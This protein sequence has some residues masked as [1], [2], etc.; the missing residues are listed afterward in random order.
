MKKWK[1]DGMKIYRIILIIGL[2]TFITTLIY[3]VVE[4]KDNKT[5]CPQKNTQN[6]SKSLNL[7][8]YMLKQPQKK[9]K[10]VDYK[11]DVSKPVGE[12]IVDLMFNGKAVKETDTFKLAINNYRYGGLKS[13]GIIDGEPYFESD[14]ATQDF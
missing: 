5:I 10:G 14:L 8:E 3:Y 13:M 1:L 6:S 7:M 9:E 12:R 11:V 2:F 4:R